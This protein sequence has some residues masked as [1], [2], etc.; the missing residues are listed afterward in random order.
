MSVS[1]S[2]Q[3]TQSITLTNNTYKQV[4]SN[5]SNYQKY[6]YEESSKQSL[7][8][9]IF[10][11]FNHI[12]SIVWVCWQALSFSSGYNRRGCNTLAVVLHKPILLLNILNIRKSGARYCLLKWLNVG[13]SDNCDGQGFSIIPTIWWGSDMF[14]LLSWDCIIGRA[15]KEE[16]VG[17][18]ARERAT[19]YCLVAQEQAGRMYVVPGGRWY[20]V[21]LCH[22][23]DL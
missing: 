10:P 14:R 20:V 5:L 6:L 21:Y 2:L 9:H 15:K 23:D 12:W 16:E 4:P 3:S 17:Q 11:S 19:D 22:P 18:R 13:N 8:D 7:G 1:A